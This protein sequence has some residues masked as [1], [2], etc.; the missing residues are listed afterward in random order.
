MRHLPNKTGPVIQFLDIYHGEHDEKKNDAEMD[1]LL[2]SNNSY[3]NKNHDPYSSKDKKPATLETTPSS[4]TNHRKIRQSPAMLASFMVALA[5]VKSLAP[6]TRQPPSHKHT[7]A[8]NT[9]PLSKLKR[10]SSVISWKMQHVIPYEPTYQETFN[11]VY[12][13]NPG[14]DMDRLPLPTSLEPKVWFRTTL[15]SSLRFL[16]MGDS[17]GIQIAQLL[18]EAF[19]RTRRSRVFVLGIYGRWWWCRWIPDSPLVVAT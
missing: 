6:S 8:Y 16:V 1:K 13:C 18:Q 15:T 19:G 5:L 11:P 10:T 2:V 12:Q 7:N 17:V 9:H 4:W 14:G 3:N